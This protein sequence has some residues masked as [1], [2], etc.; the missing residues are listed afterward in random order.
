VKSFTIEVLKGKDWSM[1][2]S[3]TTIGYKRIIKLSDIVTRKL[4]ISINDSK[5]CPVISNIE[6]Y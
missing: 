1:V 2:A 6:V 3:G 5:A 4:R